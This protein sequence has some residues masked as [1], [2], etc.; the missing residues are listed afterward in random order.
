M[1]GLGQLLLITQAADKSGT[2]HT[3]RF[4]MEQGITVMAVPNG[5]NDSN[6]AGSNNLIKT[7]AGLVSS[8]DDVLNELGII[9]HE[10]KATLVRGR[11][12]HEQKLLD[13]ML[14]GINDGEDLANMCGFGISQYNQA[15]TMLELSG[16]IR[17]LGANQWAIY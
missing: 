13:L 11:N 10:T 2:L 9:S 4:A 5:I 12:A 6:F 3:A 14:Q 17:A 16:K 7:G 15:L 1:S 8:V